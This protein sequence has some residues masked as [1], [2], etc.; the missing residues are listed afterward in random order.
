MRNYLFQIC[1]V[2]ISTLFVCT[3]NAQSVDKVISHLKDEDIKKM[4]S[5]DTES[6]EVTSVA[7]IKFGISKYSFK[8]E[9]QERFNS[10]YEEEGNIIIIY[11]VSIGHQDYDYAIFYFKDE[12]FVAASFEKS[13]PLN[14]FQAA[15]KFRDN[16]ADRYR[17]K[18]TNMICSTGPAKINY[19]QCGRPY[20]CGRRGIDGKL[21][22][23]YPIMIEL[24]KW[25]S[26]GG[27][28]KYYVMVNY[29]R[30]RIDDVINED[31]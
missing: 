20:A 28:D 29:F 8:S 27:V 24:Y 11:N 6:A 12:K 17:L 3:S 1:I 4:Q 31:I 14:N 2:T 21:I 5:I 22:Y 10:P 30:D 7:G 13:F 9:L 15:K 26:R 25:K 18:Y 16:I 23:T 19:Y